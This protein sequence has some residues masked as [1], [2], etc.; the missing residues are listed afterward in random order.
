MPVSRVETEP[1]SFW[2]RR[3]EGANPRDGEHQGIDGGAAG[4]NTDALRG[5]PWDE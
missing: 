2:P 1:G 5:D 3:R 4:V